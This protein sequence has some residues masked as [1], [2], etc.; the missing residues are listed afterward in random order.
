MNT[1]EAVLNAMSRPALDKRVLIR[2]TSDTKGRID[3]LHRKNKNHTRSSIARAALLIG[4]KHLEETEVRNGN[5][6]D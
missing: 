1:T 4:L 5:G 6:T 3:K 2:C